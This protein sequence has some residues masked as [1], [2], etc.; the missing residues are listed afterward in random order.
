MG[1]ALFEAL[2]QVLCSRGGWTS[3]VLLTSLHTLY[4]DWANRLPSNWV[5]RMKSV[6]EKASAFHGSRPS[7]RLYSNQ[8]W[9]W[10]GDCTDD[11]WAERVRWL[12]AVCEQQTDRRLVSVCVREEFAFIAEHIPF[13]LFRIVPRQ[14]FALLRRAI[15]VFRSTGDRR[16]L[17]DA[18]HLV[19]HILAI[20]N[21]TL[22]R[23]LERTHRHGSESTW[24]GKSFSEPFEMSMPYFHQWCGFEVG[25][26]YSRLEYRPLSGI[27]ESYGDFLTILKQDAAPYLTKYERGY[28]LSDV[29]FYIDCFKTKVTDIEGP[30]GFR[31]CVTLKEETQR[32]T[33]LTLVP[34]SR[35]SNVQ[36]AESDYSSTRN[37]DPESSSHASDLESETEVHEAEGKITKPTISTHSV[38]F[39]GPSNLEDVAEQLDHYLS[40]PVP[41]HSGKAEIIPSD[42]GKL[43]TNNSDSSSLSLAQNCLLTAGDTSD[44]NSL[45]LSL[46][47]LLE[48]TNTD[49]VEDL[50]RLERSS[51]SETKS[52]WNGSKQEPECS[53]SS[54]LSG[55]EPDS[56][57][58][59]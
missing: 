34:N 6:T 59:F 31:N 13:I 16:M 18:L 22:Q 25:D 24:D 32:F 38:I 10:F 29:E 40:R 4:T 8:T 17:D 46:E 35:H 12:A 30:R 49:L 39:T 58:V 9:N 15:E 53:I 42:G 20:T 19:S 14:L 1:E 2:D 51:S 47:Y 33:L 26:D 45:N 7:S 27:A 55:H 21:T 43:Y 28:Y 44:S 3:E 52:D 41:M 48:T 50:E 56:V 54:E 23:G 57:N 37:S 5:S 11:N 36:S